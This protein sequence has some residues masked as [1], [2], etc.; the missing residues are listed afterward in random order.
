MTILK[1]TAKLSAGLLTA[2]LVLAGCSNDPEPTE[3]TDPT[4]AT[5][6]TTE[7]TEE[8]TTEESPIEE[9]PSEEPSVE[10]SPSQEPSTEQS[11]SGQPSSEPSMGQD[12][13]FHGTGYTLKVPEGYKQS[14]E[15]A[16]Q[17][18]VMFTDASGSGRMN[19]ITTPL[20]GST[21]LDSL[22]EQAKPTLEK[23]FDKMS[24]A[25][26]KTLD[27]EPAKGFTGTMNGVTVTQ[28]Y[29]MHNDQVFILSFGG[30]AAEEVDKFISGWKWTS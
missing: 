3:P 2:T 21:D 18:E 19:V 5:E 15:G 11:P 25:P 6:P 24:D 13:T 10:E 8:P 14:T 1:N 28:Y 7:A 4:T 9:S 26:Q 16:Q 17:V 30:G 22:L 12:G 23:Q 27:G 20:P 29:S